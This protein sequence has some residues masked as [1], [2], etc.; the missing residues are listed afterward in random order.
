MR[1]IKKK[2]E[3]KMLTLKIGALLANIT[4]IACEGYTLWH[5]RGKRN[6]LKY[7]TYLQ[8]LLA[9][10]AS[11]VF[12]VCLVLEMLSG[13]AMPEFAK[14]LRYIAACGLM[15]VMLIFVLFLGRAKKNAIEARDLLNGF[16]PQTANRILHYFCPLLSLASFL[17]LERPFPLHNGIWTGLAAIPSCAYWAMYFLL[18]ITRAWK[19]PYDFSSQGKKN[20]LREML[21][22]FLMPLLFEIIVFALWQIK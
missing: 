17:V 13:R 14:G 3:I 19:E 18:S 8:N 22:F 11:V 5:I 16:S 7:Y 21:P 9:M 4:L 10:I 1:Y 15:A 12:S 6:L 20:R 2:A